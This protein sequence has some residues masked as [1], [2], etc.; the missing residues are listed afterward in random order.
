MQRIPAAQSGQRPRPLPFAGHLQSASPAQ[1]SALASTQDP[2]GAR[3]AP[4]AAASLAALVRA[5]ASPAR[6]GLRALFDMI[7][8]P[9]ARSA[10]PTS[11]PS[12]PDRTVSFTR[13]PTDSPSDNEADPE[14]PPQAGEEPGWEPESALMGIPPSPGGPPHAWSPSPRSAAPLP[15]GASPSP[16]ARGRR[17]PPASARSPLPPPLSPPPP[18]QSSP[19]PTVWLRPRGL[20]FDATPLAA[21]AQAAVGTAPSGADRLRALYPSHAQAIDALEERASR[22]DPLLLGG[23]TPPQDLGAL[24]AAY[25]R[26]VSPAGPEDARRV[27]GALD[28]LVSRQIDAQRLDQLARQGRVRDLARAVAG[29]CFKYSLSFMSATLAIGALSERLLHEAQAADAPPTPVA[30]FMAQ[31]LVFLVGSA[32]IGAGM[33]MANAAWRAGGLADGYTRMRSAEGQDHSRWVQ[34]AAALPFALLYATHDTHQGPMGPAD[35]RLGWGALAAAASGAWG[36]LGPLLTGARQE[37]RWIDGA[38]DETR[39]TM[40]RSLDWLENPA[41]A[42]CDLFRQCLD[43]PW[44]GIRLEALLPDQPAVMRALARSGAASLARVV[45][46]LAYAFDGQSDGRWRLGADIVLGTS[47]GLLSTWPDAAWR[48]MSSTGRRPGSAAMARPAPPQDVAAVA[49]PRMSPSA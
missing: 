4:A 18:L 46:L 47:W 21:S 41:A 42:A 45:N 10:H 44:Q 37:S 6:I 11:S 36:Q 8:P 29:A 26:H 7:T 22:R 20:D 1:H 3:S 15:D 39:R 13:L 24:L 27:L 43:S 12:D 14:A 31:A 17:G 23:K 40:I 16:A 49:P 48:W 25:E 30:D 38:S 9:L 32:I 28:L 5:V 2:P 34:G 35:A 33:E 19:V